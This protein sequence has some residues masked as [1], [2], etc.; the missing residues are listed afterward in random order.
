MPRHGPSTGDA[1]KR[2]RRDARDDLDAPLPAEDARARPGATHLV[3]PGLPPRSG[4]A[5]D[6]S[7]H[8]ARQRWHHLLR[9]PIPEEKRRLLRDLWEGLSD[10]LRRL[11]GQGLGRQTT[12]CGA[13]I[14]VMPRCDFDC[15]GCYLGADANAAAP[16]P[17]EAVLAQLDHLRQALG[18][19][20]NVQITDGEV[21]LSPR[22]ELLRIVRHARAVGLIPMLMT[23]GDTFRRQPELLRE[24]VSTAG[25][26]ELSIHV[27][28][29]QRGRREPYA[30]ARSEAA[31]MPLREEL[32]GHLR[33]VR[34]DTG[35]RLRAAMTLTVSEDN[36]AEVP[37]VVRWTL[38][39][40]DVFVL[41]SFQPLAHVGRTRGDL[42]GVAVDRLWARIDEALAPLGAAA[43]PGGPGTFQVGHPDC[44][45][46]QMLLLVETP[47]RPLRAIPLARPWS[48]RDQEVIEGYFAR[49]LG[50]VVFRDDPPF[51]RLAR[52]VGFFLQAPGWLLGPALRW[53][54]ARLREAGVRPIPLL[55]QLLLGRARI[56]PF[57]VVS[58]H[59]MTAAEL[60]TPRGK[61]RL[62][63]CVFRVPVAGE[64][65]PMCEVNANGLRDRVYRIGRRSGGG[66]GTPS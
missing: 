61:E 17:D 42:R 31:L 39:N 40:R 12:G 51:H 62:D 33:Q 5:L 25:L 18:P 24:L 49:D 1:V 15:R 30:S 36:L 65:R 47:G 19:K 26:T 22:P 57:T 52:G 35:V 29:L 41:I 37:A 34:R 14:G 59:F 10:D 6:S 7:V 55:A 48:R 2:H 64:L 44:T 3:T 28:S 8:P 46:M 56:D 53:A 27:D 16:L 58:H 11:P 45:R 32:A 9:Q 50:G 60:A 38:A 54:H 21:T 43:G 23:H 63:A 20:G 4:A 66:D 13:T